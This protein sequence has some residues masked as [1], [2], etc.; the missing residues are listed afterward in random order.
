MF[1]VNGQY[2]ALLVGFPIG[3]IMPFILYFAQKK[4][5]NQTWL[6]QA[7][8]VVMLYGA[9]TLAPYNIGYVWPSVPIAWLSMVY[10][11]KK[12]LGAW[13]KVRSHPRAILTLFTLI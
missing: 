13:S 2:T 8:P 4:F 1:G 11:K 3:F 7:H 6:R 5:K 12:Y 9:L 10:M